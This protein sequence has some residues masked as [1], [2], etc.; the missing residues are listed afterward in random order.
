MAEQI[1]EQA[2]QEE[3]PEEKKP[4][5]KEEEHEV[6]V[7]I[8]SYDIPGSRS[9]YS[10]LTRI[11]GVSWAISNAACISLKLSRSKKVSELSKPEIEK[12]ESFLQ[13]LKIPDFLKN[14]QKDLETGQTAHFYGNDLD[15][16]KEF[17][18]KRLKQI[19]SYKGIRHSSKLPVRGQRTRANFR[20]KGS[21]AVGVTKKAT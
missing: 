7:R 11:K 17:D 15:L 8:L 13:E 18:I 14:R 19:H 20:S 16:K 10:G 6:L 3:K 21:A 2:K 9:L 5:R 1:K 12:I 4:E